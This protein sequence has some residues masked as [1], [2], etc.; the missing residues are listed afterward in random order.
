MVPTLVAI[1]M[2]FGDHVLTSFSHSILPQNEERRQCLLFPST[3]SLSK[4]GTIKVCSDFT[5]PYLLPSGALKPWR[6]LTHL[7]VSDMSSQALATRLGSKQNCFFFR[8][9]IAG[10]LVR[11]S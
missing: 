5:R 10:K 3:S 2:E 8:P 7:H 9:S 1:L 4:R 6:Y 11:I